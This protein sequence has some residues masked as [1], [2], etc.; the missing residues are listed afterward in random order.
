MSGYVRLQFTGLEEGCQLKQIFNNFFSPRH[1]S[2]VAYLKQIHSHKMNKTFILRVTVQSL[3]NSKD[4]LLKGS[5]KQH[6]GLFVKI[7]LIDKIDS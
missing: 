3:Y 7:I 5:L 2:A 1:V 6:L 4:T